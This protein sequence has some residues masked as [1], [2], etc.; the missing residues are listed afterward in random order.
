MIFVD[1]RYT[2]FYPIFPLTVTINYNFL[3][4]ANKPRLEGVLNA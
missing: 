3:V 4:S 1:F 2:N